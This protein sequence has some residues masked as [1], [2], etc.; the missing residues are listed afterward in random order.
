MIAYW[1]MASSNYSL[2]LLNG[3]A[4]VGN[5]LVSTNIYVEKGEIALIS[6]KKL[7]ATEI[8]DCTNL[9]VLPGVIDSQVHFRE[10]G[11]EGK[12]TLSSGMLAAVAGGVT[13][14]FEMPNTNPPT[15]NLIEF[16]KKIKK[17]LFLLPNLLSF[18]KKVFFF[19]I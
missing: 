12:E 8:I 3:Q 14:I 17:N 18:F 13:S 15:A 4:M 19:E 6:D 9:I 11:L 7:E 2:C 5:Q 1:I 16:D 10:P